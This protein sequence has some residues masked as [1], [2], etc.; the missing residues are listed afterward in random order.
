VH[1]V[2]CHGFRLKD[3]ELSF[4][5]EVSKLKD[6]VNRHGNRVHAVYQIQFHRTQIELQAAIIFG[7]ARQSVKIVDLLGGQDRQ[8]GVTCHAR[9]AFRECKKYTFR[10]VGW[11]CPFIVSAAGLPVQKPLL[12]TKCISL[13]YLLPFCTMEASGNNISE[14]RIGYARVS[15]IGQ[16]LDSQVDALQKAGCKKIFSDKMMGSRMDR[17][18][19]DQIIEY[20]RAGDALVVTELSRMTR[21]LM[22]L[23]E[24]A[25]LLEQ[26]HVNL[27]SLRE[28]IDTSTATGRCFLSMMGAIHQMERELRAERASSGRASAKARG[29]T[30]GRPR[31]DVAKLRDAKVLYEN[32][33]K[34]A[35]EVCKV[36]GVGRRIFFSYL[37]KQRET[38]PA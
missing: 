36:V 23:L 14:H 34:T 28:N 20:V 1:Y 18:G 26:K 27:V 25:Q 6:Q 15:S 17:P 22:H 5:L 4:G 21:S 16:N 30:G 2:V 9:A 13:R 8:T 37:A 29:K 19:W 24:T 10:T 35:N 38:T 31:T 33:G 12:K 11:R 32:S 3:E 7:K